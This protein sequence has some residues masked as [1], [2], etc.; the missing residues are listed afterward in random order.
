MQDLEKSIASILERNAKVEAE[1]AW[2]ISMY[3]RVCITIFTYIVA[4]I[5]LW[6]IDTSNFGLHALVPTGGYVFSLLSLPWI[7]ERWI[8]KHQK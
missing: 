3:R 5:F 1:K 7:K 6:L 2:E 8:A 4:C